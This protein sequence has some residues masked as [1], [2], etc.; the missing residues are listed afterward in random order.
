MEDS[1]GNTHLFYRM[2]TFQKDGV[3]FGDYYENSIHHL[4]MNNGIDSIFLKDGQFSTE[5]TTRITDV[6]FWNNDPTKFIYCGENV[7]VDPVAFIRRF[8]QTDNAFQMLGE[9]FNL[10]IGKQNDSL[11]IASAPNLIKSTDG[12]FSWNSFYDSISYARIVSISPYNNDVIFFMYNGA[13]LLKS[14]D[15]GTTLHLVDT[16]QSGI[17]VMV[18]DIDSVHV[19]SISPNDFSVSNN[20]G[21]AFSW[22]KRYYSST[23]IQV[24]IDRLQSGKIFLC[25]GK[26]ILVSED[27]GLTFN[28]YV[29]LD[30]RI[31]GIYKKNEFR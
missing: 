4:D 3:P 27:Y 9:A 26:R 14:E 19:Y 21:N 10:E 7:V 16:S 8:D 24:S 29:T 25:D 15:G 5:N 13:G 30:R 23:P 6:E 11:I 28:E 17:P 12:G 1:S 18:F 22:I 20:Y 31:V 2:Y